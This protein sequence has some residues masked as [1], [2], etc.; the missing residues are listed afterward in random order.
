MNDMQGVGQKTVEVR[1]VGWGSDTI[2]EFFEAVRGQQF[3]T[4]ANNVGGFYRVLQDVDACFVKITENLTHPQNLLSAVLLVSSHSA[5][6]AACSTS[7]GTQLPETFVL[8]RSCLEYA[9]YGLHVKVNPRLGEIWVRRHDDAAALRAMKKAF[10]GV[11]VEETIV[12]TDA[13][14]GR[15]YSELYERTIDF[16]GHPN[17]RGVVTNALFQ[18]L[19]DKRQAQ[20]IY[21]HGNETTIAHALKTTAQVG[22]CSLHLFQHVFPERFLL[23]QLREQLIE[24]RKGL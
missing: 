13:E 4:F 20:L 16:G 23:L 1:P 7:M 18:E 6:R 21:L 9:G 22:L 3:A 8:L 10:Q 12:A 5:Y 2:S 19:P 14:L 11:E 15:V 17:L 24:L